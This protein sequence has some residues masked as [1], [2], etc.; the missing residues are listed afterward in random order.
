MNRPLVA[1][2]EVLQLALA[3]EHDALLAGQPDALHVAT[4]EKLDALR[5]VE[6]LRTR[7]PVAA[8]DADTHALVDRIAAINRTN[9]ALIAAGRR[10]AER[11]LV[12]LGRLSIEPDYD[13]AGRSSVSVHSR[14][15][16]A[17]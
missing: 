2:L 9:G 17:A 10:S 7:T 11:A 15:L 1:A 8:L 3:H 5:V 12:R 14:A 13:D 6:G 4:A 16:G